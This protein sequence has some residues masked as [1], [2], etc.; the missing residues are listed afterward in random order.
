MWVTPEHCWAFPG[1]NFPGANSEVL[2]FQPV[3]SSLW[4]VT[5]LNFVGRLVNLFTRSHR[6]DAADSE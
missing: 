4:I 3:S 6:Q 5:H 1:A 2:V